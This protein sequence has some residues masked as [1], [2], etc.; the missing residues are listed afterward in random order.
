MIHARQ[1]VPPSNSKTSETVVLVGIPSELNTSRRM[2]SVS[3]TAM[4]IHMISSK[5]N[6]SGRKIPWRA[7]SIMP[8]LTAAPTKTPTAATR[9]IRLSVVTL[10]PTAELRKL[11]ASFDTPTHRSTIAS[12][13]R[14]IIIKR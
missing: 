10:L 4:K 1:K 6:C 12:E 8:L 3:M 5:E 11:T 2:T 9:M 14:K 7:M 13:K